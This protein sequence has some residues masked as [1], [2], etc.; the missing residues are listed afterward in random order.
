MFPNSVQTRPAIGV[1]GDFASYNP[2]ASVNA[3][4]GELIAGTA[5]LTA[6][7]FA[8]R[9]GSNPLRL[10]N[11]GSGAPI[12]FIGRHWEATITVFLAE[13]GGVGGILPG[14]N[15]T[16]YKAGDFFALNEGAGAATIGMKAYAE[17]TTGRVQ[18]AATGASISGW[19]ET[20]WFAATA[21][22]AGEVVVISNIQ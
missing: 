9:D 4:E 22:A 17:L 16:A 2:H 1:A 15:A 5:G 13:F 14:R 12:G 20:K 10:N 6:G 8:W 21:G 19:V 11:S 18:F 7:R 3:L